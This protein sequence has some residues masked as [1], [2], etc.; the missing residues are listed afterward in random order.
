MG[1]AAYNL[2]SLGWNSFQQLCLTVTREIL[3]QTVESFLDSN[4]GGR[5][6]AF[7]GTWTPCGGETLSGR[8]VIQCKFTS[9]EDIN[10]HASDLCDEVEKARRLVEKGLCDAYVLLTN[11]GISG[12]GAEKIEAAY[13]AVGVKNVLLCGSTWIC[14]QIQESKRLRMLVPRVYGLGDLSQILDGRVYAQARALLA[15]LRDDLSKV[16]VTSAYRRAAA[17]LDQ[18]GFVLL[19]GEPAAGKTTIAS[20]LAMAALDQWN[21]ST[22]KL[23]EPGKVVD[24]WNPG[25]PAQFFWVDDAFGVSQ[26][27]S[28]LVQGWNH[29]LAQVKAMLKKGAKIVMTSRDYIYNR[30]RKDLKESAFPLLRESQVVIDVRDLTLDEKRQILYN[31]LK[32]GRQPQQF[33]AHIKPLLEGVAAH[34]RF[35]PETARRLGDPVFTQGLYI[36]KF[37]IDRFVERQEQL[38][39]EVLQ[40]LDGDSKAALGL[41]YMRNGELE[42]PI[43]LEESEGRALERLG[44]GL[45]G[46]TTAL[47]SLDGSLVLHA[48]VEGV[49]MWRFKHPTI[50][51]AFGAL[52][53]R[54]P[55]LL[56]I[57]IQG[58]LT[59]DLM[60]HVTCGD[61]GL[62]KAVII[63]K[64]LFPLMLR[65]LDEYSSSPRYKSPAYS[66][67]RAQDR[68]NGFLARRCSKEFLSF[69]VGKHPELLDRVAEPGLMLSAVSE[70]DLAVRLHKHGLLPERQ[71]LKFLETVVGY[72]LHGEDLYALTDSGIRSVFTARA[73]EIF[74]QLVRA[75][76]VPRLAKVRR[77]WQANYSYS[78]DESADD[79][80]APLMDIFEALTK[81]FVD[82]DEVKTIVRRETNRLNEW[83]ADHT[84]EEP[85]DKPGRTLGDIETPDQLDDARSIFDDIDA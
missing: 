16:V 50:G 67:W 36:G 35:V 38:L 28:L 55:E 48:H 30:A 8:F 12:T 60:D 19:I 6:G 2:Y 61:V 58:S 22:L 47:E 77:E 70:V 52:L 82:D 65:R 49:S 40:G 73:F 54:N 37:W 3:G 24:H 32:L 53:V 64:S 51:D 13:K 42:S 21:A 83:I 11:A 85:A 31:H 23:D 41:I 10:L 46:C 15:S 4:D 39:Q 45:G 43:Q 7:T 29:R 56:Q 79:F 57:Y 71:R 68:I 74:R 76:F 59:D 1:E 62:E 63:P 80:M 5:D 84:E 26:Y 14:Q 25:E 18:H 20:L 9:K 69:Y 81:E 17:A 78:S 75:E 33:R 66:V 72:A 34:P 27:E 44:S